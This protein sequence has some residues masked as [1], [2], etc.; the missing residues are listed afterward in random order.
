MN[1][2]ESDIQR[3]II[4]YLKLRKDCVV[5]RLNNVGVPLKNGRFRPSPVKGLPDLVLLVGT[6]QAVWLEVK[7]KKG[8]QSENQKHF[9]SEVKRM[10]GKYFVVRSVND[11][12]EI[13]R[14]VKK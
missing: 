5:Y 3:A 11:V 7:T 12:I 9:E 10:K 4:D 6:G 13:L 8:K 14:K 2:K 1:E